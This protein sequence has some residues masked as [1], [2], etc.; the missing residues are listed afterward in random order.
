MANPHPKPHPENLV[1]VEVLNA[2]R[3]KEEHI[4]ASRKGALRSNEVQREKK[5]FREAVRLI[6]EM[7]CLNPDIDE[8]LKQSGLQSNNKNGIALAMALKAMQ[9][10]KQ[11]ADW[12]RDTAGEKPS[13][14]IDV[15]GGS[16]VIAIKGEDQL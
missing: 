1:P 8:I 9:G 7:P 3:T 11:A 15:K 4:E 13:N 10:D 16:M 14:D 6:S 2:R 5:A 12:V